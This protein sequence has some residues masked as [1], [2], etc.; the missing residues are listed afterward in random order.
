[1]VGYQ[2]FKR[3]LNQRGHFDFCSRGRGL[4]IT[5]GLLSCKSIETS[6]HTHQET[7]QNNVTR[8]AVEFATEQ[9]VFQR[10]RHGALRF[11]LDPVALLALGG[12]VIDF[13]ARRAPG[14]T[15]NNRVQQQS[16]RKPQT[17]QH[18]AQ[19]KEHQRQPSPERQMREQHEINRGAGLESR[20]RATEEVAYRLTCSQMTLSHAAHCLTESASVTTRQ[21]RDRY[22]LSDP[23]WTKA[24]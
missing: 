11:V 6:S 7:S 9:E 17:K 3:S 16:V 2:A 14:I 22:Q 21:K 5:L 15:G 23:T 18:K 4:A 20:K 12:A 1:V 10:T 13:L 19:T 24:N 8:I